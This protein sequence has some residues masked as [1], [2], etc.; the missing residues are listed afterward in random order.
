MRDEF[1]KRFS[2]ANNKILSLRKN[3]SI[4]EDQL[5]TINVDIEQK[6]EDGLVVK[7]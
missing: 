3:V 1:N 4:L 6:T 7:P 2:T 5:V